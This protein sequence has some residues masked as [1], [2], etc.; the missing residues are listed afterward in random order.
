MIAQRPKRWP[1][2]GTEEFRLFPRREV[3]PLVDLMEVD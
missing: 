2:F 3:P 1:E